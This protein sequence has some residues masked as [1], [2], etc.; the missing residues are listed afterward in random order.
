MEKVVDEVQLVEMFERRNESPSEKL[1][2]N[3]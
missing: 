2:M 1:C 3:F